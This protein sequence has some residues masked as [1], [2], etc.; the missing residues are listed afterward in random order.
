[1]SDVS[2]MSGT[3]WHVE[4]IRKDVDDKRRHRVRCKYYNDGMCL[5]KSASCVGSAHCEIYNDPNDDSN[6]SNN[7]N[8]N[9][10]HPYYADANYMRH[11]RDVKNDKK[12]PKKKRWY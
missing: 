2:K 4:T 10:E 7:L 3:P 11:L 12:K 1:M 5:Y 9:N 6:T 8:P